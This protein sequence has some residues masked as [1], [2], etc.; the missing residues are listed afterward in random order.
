MIIAVDADDVER[1]LEI[2]TKAG[3]TA[4]VVGEIK[5]GASEQQVHIV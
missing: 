3:E 1:S 4:F 2:L 5:D